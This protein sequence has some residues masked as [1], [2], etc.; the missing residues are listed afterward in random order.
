MRAVRSGSGYRDIR[1]DTY[2][3]RV[4]PV[5]ARVLQKQ[6]RLMLAPDQSN[7]GISEVSLGNSKKPP[8]NRLR[9]RFKLAVNTHKL[10]LHVFMFC[11]E[12][13]DNP[14]NYYF[15]VYLYNK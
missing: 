7:V 10:L 13:Q 12:I 5:H 2:T 1:A 15:P 4:S 11:F 8:E 9:F 3:S 14:V 6:H